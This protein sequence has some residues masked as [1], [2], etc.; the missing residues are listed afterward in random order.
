MLKSFLF[1]NIFVIALFG[2]LLEKFGMPGPFS[3]L[4]EFSIYLLLLLSLIKR[5]GRKISIPKFWYIF[6]CF[7]L[8]TPISSLLN[9]TPLFRS[10]ESIR[11]LFRFYFFYLAIIWLEPND[12]FIKN[13]MIFLLIIIIFQ[14]PVIFYKF[15]TYGIAEITMGAWVRA[16]S[17]TAMLWF[18][19]LFFLASFYYLYRPKNYLIL[20]G[21][22][23]VL[24]SIVGAKRVVFFLFPIQFISIYYYIYL[25]GTGA[26]FSKKVVT[27][28]VV[29][30][31]IS[32]IS[33]SILYLNK[34]LNPEGEI[35]GDINLSYALEYANR[36]NMGISASGYSYGRVAT[37]KR[38]FEILLD[39]GI[40]HI[41]LGMGPG[42][43][44]PT[45]LDSKNTRRIFEQ[46]YEKFK[47]TYG[48]T[49]ITRILL[50]YGII[51]S[52]L[53]G[54]MIYSFSVKCWRLYLIEHDPY[55]KAFAGGSFGFSCS[56]LFFF[57]CYSHNA[58]WGIVM[59]SLYFF[60][61]AVIQIKLNHK[62][63][64]V[65]VRSGINM[66]HSSY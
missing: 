1:F 4:S 58:F 16:G 52:M 49:P 53:Y 19:T 35:G 40:S 63:Q 24:A 18:S 60:S 8:I 21:I 32:F 47:I 27:L 6:F 29:L 44:T 20:I 22:G 2:G 55:W 30:V 50:E 64:Y 46:R 51:A 26:S 17:V 5:S 15:L 33:G 65:E 11:L 66:K 54:W 31:L 45:H 39:S 57:L 13:I 23:C 3:L 56:M 7:L 61:M 43:T 42:S 14:F 10:I 9:D 28:S 38:V 62:E 48:L 36:Y 34:S 12:K 25:M 37:T 59:P 41:V